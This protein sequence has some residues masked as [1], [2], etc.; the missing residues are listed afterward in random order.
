MAQDKTTLAESAQAI[1]CSL[2]DYLGSSESN[3]RLDLKRYKTFEE[4]L[5]FS[6]NK[7]DLEKAQDFVKVDG[8]IKSVYEFLNQKNGWY[9]SSIVIANKLVN[10]LKAI[11]PDYKIAK[12]EN[13]YFYLRG[14]VGV[15]KDVAELWSI[16]AKSNVT[17]EQQKRIP[18]FIGFKDIN[19]W[20]PAD[21]YLANKTGKS[22][23]SKELLQAKKDI[24]SYSFDFLNE[25]IKSLIDKGAILPLS[26][27]KTKT[28]AKLVKVNFLKASKD[29]VLKNVKFVGTTN[30]Q[31]YKML[32]ETPELSFLALKNGGKTETRD[33]QIMLTA[34]GKQGVIKIR[35]DPSG[36][37]STGRLVIELIMKGDAAKGGSIASQIALH[38]LWKTI[39]TKTAGDFLKAYD[40][41][42]KEF[43]R[44][45]KE[46]LKVKDKLRS[47]NN[48]ATGDRNKY[49]HYLAIAS[50]TNIINGIMPIIKKWF[51]ENN[52]GEQ[53][54]SNKLI[55]LLFQIATSRSPLSSRFVI[56]K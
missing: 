6:Q 48:P 53:G 4:F 43:S 29:E 19:K 36:S 38:D 46:Y 7:K 13:D 52:Q 31:P 11:D 35:H 25:K 34:E 32:D 40:K 27:K 49:D 42:L 2:A 37:S 18:T 30:W 55:R 33:I 20:N 17:K 54:K 9:E 56:A 22:E 44:L 12:K 1:F 10:D 39:D 50:A 41:G 8:N 26:L 3:K 28:N 47:D 23:I 5:S 45:K 16:A 21:I 15:M 24:K 14:N 51:K